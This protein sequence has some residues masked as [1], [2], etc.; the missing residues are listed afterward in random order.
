MGKRGEFAGECGTLCCRQ[1]GMDA[2]LHGGGALQLLADVKNS[3]PQPAEPELPWARATLRAVRLEKSRGED[4]SVA[5]V[6][7]VWA[8]AEDDW[9]AFCEK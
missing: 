8:F 9:F 3:A 4:F 1:R 7:N 6:G 2:L 5:G